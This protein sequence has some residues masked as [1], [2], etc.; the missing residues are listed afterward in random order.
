MQDH[1]LLIIWGKDQASWKNHGYLILLC[2]FKVCSWNLLMPELLVTRLVW[3]SLGGYN[4]WSSHGSMKKLLLFLWLAH[5]L[6]KVSLHITLSGSSTVCYLLEGL[7]FVEANSFLNTAHFSVTH[8]DSCDNLF[9]TD[10]SASQ[11]I[12]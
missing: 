2:H 12:C 7:F 9:V 3:L 1:N 11:F 10:V 6:S 4:P 8:S 5:F